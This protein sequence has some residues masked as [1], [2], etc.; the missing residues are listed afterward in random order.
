MNRN[1]QWLSVCT[2]VLPGGARSAK[3]GR[4]RP[5][6][7]GVALAWRFGLRRYRPPSGV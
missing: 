5:R 2:A 4:R 6:Q 7:F 3:R 1:R